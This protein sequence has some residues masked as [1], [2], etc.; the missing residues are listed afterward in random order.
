M[1]G[2]ITVE[3]R[4]QR[5]EAIEITERLERER[6]TKTRDQKLGDYSE[7]LNTSQGHKFIRDKPGAY[8]P[9]S[10]SFEAETV[11]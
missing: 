1:L 7:G 10:T 8:R 4:G 3:T 5:L 6:G 11:L 2:K 9:F